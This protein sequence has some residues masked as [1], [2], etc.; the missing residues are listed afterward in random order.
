VQRSDDNGTVHGL[1]AAGVGFAFVPQLVADAANGDLA[2]LEVEESLPPRRI[3]IA[4]RKDR[5]TPAALE[6]FV[7]EVA[8]TCVD[9]GLT[10]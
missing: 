5:Q 7:Q 10:A 2:V 8:A 3:A 4:A 6:T 9:L 1:V